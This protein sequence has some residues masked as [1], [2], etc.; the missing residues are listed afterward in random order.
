M[1]VTDFKVIVLL[2]TWNGCLQMSPQTDL[3]SALPLN[4]VSL[5]VS[6]LVTDNQVFCVIADVSVLNETYQIYMYSC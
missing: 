4:Q 2:V 1:A 3:Q 5:N 6:G